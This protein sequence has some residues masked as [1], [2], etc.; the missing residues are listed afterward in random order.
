M[1]KLNPKRIWNNLSDKR[2]SQNQHDEAPAEPAESHAVYSQNLKEFCDGLRGAICENDEE[3]KLRRA[4][5]E[6]LLQ[7]FD[8]M[9]ACKS[10]TYNGVNQDGTIIIEQLAEVDAAQH[11]FDDHYVE[12]LEYHEYAGELVIP[13]SVDIKAYLARHFFAVISSELWGGG[14]W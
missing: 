14:R 12:I 11:F 7:Q 3:S 1:F 2:E 6:I 5:A 8:P 4:V 10:V 13:G 9:K